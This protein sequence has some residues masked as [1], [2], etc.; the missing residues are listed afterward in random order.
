MGRMNARGRRNTG[1]IL[2]AL[3]L[4]VA[5]SAVRAGT[6][7]SIPLII[8]E[9]G[10]FAFTDGSSVFRF[11]QDGSFRMEP[12][13]LSGRAI[14]G[15]WTSESPG[16]FLITGV[17]TWY[18]GISVPDDFRRMTMTVTLLPGE[19]DTV[20]TLWG[21]SESQLYPVYFVIDTVTGIDAL[22]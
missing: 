5:A 2:T 20:R 4:L 22:P 1:G 17:W 15:T 13:S 18:N 21:G 6:P 3:L 9:E 19:P 11:E 16:L 8:A 10:E 14:E 12:V 7:R